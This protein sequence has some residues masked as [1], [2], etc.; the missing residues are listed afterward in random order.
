MNTKLNLLDRTFTVVFSTHT[1]ECRKG[2]RYQR[3]CMVYPELTDKLITAAVLNGLTSFRGKGLTV[4]TARIGISQAISFVV[5]LLEDDT[6]EVVT[7]LNHPFNYYGILIK[8]AHRINLWKLVFPQ[9]TAKEVL[10]RREQGKHI[11]KRKHVT[12]T[13]TDRGPVLPKYETTK[14]RLKRELDEYKSEYD[15]KRKLN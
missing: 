1:K 9:V 13:K 3:D 5:R 12:L 7:I 15:F 14:Q 8:T 11:R 2:E 4:L 6:I 10:K